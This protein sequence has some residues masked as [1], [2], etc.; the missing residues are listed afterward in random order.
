MKKYI[1]LL[2][3]F[4]SLS[5]L[6]NE[7]P[8]EITVIGSYID[9][10]SDSN[11]VEVIDAAKYRN[12][13]I[14]NIGEISKYLN[15]SAG[16]HFQTNT[17]G[18]V[19][20]GMSAVTL[21]GLD[22]ASTLVLLNT[23]RQTIAGT[24]SHEGEGYIDVNIIPEIAL[25]RIEIL[26]EGA[27]SL[28]GSDAVAGVVNFVT[29]KEFE[30]IKLSLGNQKTTHYD[31]TDKTVG[32]IYGKKFEDAHLVVAA[33]VLNRSSLSSSEIPRIAEMGLST[34]GNTFRVSEQD[35][36][37]SG[38][39]AGDYSA[40]Q[41]VADPDCETNGGVLAGPFCKFL[42]GTRFNIVNDENHKKIY[43]NLNKIGDRFTYN[44]TAISSHV[45]VNDNPQSPSYP[46]LSFMSR[47]I[48]PGHG[49]SPFN[50]PVTW[51]GRP[52]GS[53]FPSPYSPKDIKQYH[54]SNALFFDLNEFTHAEIS[55]TQSE[56]EN[57]HNRPDTIDSRFEA[58]VLGN[59]GPNGD[60]SWNLFN[61]LE[62]DP[63]LIEYLKGSEQSFKTGKLTNVDGIIKT[64]IRGTDVVFGFQWS[65]ESLKI[66]YN[67]LGRAEFDNS[68]KLIKA[69][70]L[71][72]LGGGK[73][74]SSDRTKKAFFTEIKRTFSDNFDLKI[75]GRYEKIGSFSS[76]DPKISLRFSPLNNLTF[77]GSV[78][79]SFSTPSMAQ[80]NSSDIQL[81]GVRD[82]QNGIEQANTLFVRIVQVGNPD[83]DPATSTNANFGLIWDISEN[84]NFAMDYWTIDYKDRLELEDAQTKLFSDP[85]GPDVTRNQF[86]TLI[87]VNTTFFNEE[88][89]EVKG[90]DLSLSYF[91]E[92]EKIG[93]FDLSIKA[94]NLFDFLTPDGEVMVNRVGR[95]NYAAHTHS[96]P[97][98]RLNAFLD[99]TY[100]NTRYSL[101]GR[102]VD[103]YK[104]LRV[105]P[106]ASL[107]NGYTNKVGSFLV[108]DIAAVRLI[109]FKDQQL[110]LGI[111]LINAFDE[112]A[113]LLYNAPDFSFDTRLHDP[114]GRLLNFSLNYEF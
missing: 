15:I 51:F 82:V 90:I 5:C 112:S 87:A 52:L 56:H 22:H 27:T 37:T 76:F 96:L 100:G 19:D 105:I 41:W 97:R 58:A 36:V 31:Q 35:T 39:Y 106:E 30:G 72:F 78:G 14:T 13:N 110:T 80:L 54:V 28:Y 9:K 67:D 89:T 101:I 23:K 61:P 95:F 17:L 103:G 74:V 34:L 83:L 3:L 29:H 42:Y 65:E 40:G 24:P 38:K 68:G 59:G 21:R 85:N 93:S 16:S 79:T 113:P 49:G 20:Q 62:N 4:I 99:W 33:N 60:L 1:A 45:E 109:E 111:S 73:N 75:S 7:N 50:V 70:D 107:A 69:A 71:L 114:R 98:L 92:T 84:L 53:A 81:G 25:E 77:R 32:L 8:E 26:K 63:Q 10:E 108:F 47:Y 91:K 2:S 11:P 86:G 43:L 64:L 55:I 12:L 94:T 104:N 48:D 88:R 57:F 46:A 44:L 102:Y 66:D 18:G 6:A